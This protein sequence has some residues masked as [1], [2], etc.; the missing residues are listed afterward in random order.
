M[1]SLFGQGLQVL[2]QVCCGKFSQ[3]KNDMITI[4]SNVWAG[5]DGVLGGWGVIVRAYFNVC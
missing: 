1:S 3:N 4:K 5:Y 2:Y